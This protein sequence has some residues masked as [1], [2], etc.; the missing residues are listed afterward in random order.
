MHALRRLQSVWQARGASGFG[1]FMLSKL[2]TRRRD[3]L[4]EADTDTESSDRQWTG[5]GTLLCI[6]KENFSTAITPRMLQQIF[7]GEGADYLAGLKSED[8]LFCLLDDDGNYLHH[9]F[10]LFDT[11]TKRLLGEAVRVPLFAHCV[12]RANARGMHLYPRVL[13]HALAVLA[14]RGHTRAIVNCDPR[15]LASVAGIQRAG[16][17]LARSLNTQIV[18]SCIAWQEVRSRGGDATRRFFVG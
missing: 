2:Y 14:M 12:T 13:R 3:L 5:I 18:L 17:R 6:G 8:L 10:V 9:S 15:N 11:R 4:F 16:F 7:T 1:R